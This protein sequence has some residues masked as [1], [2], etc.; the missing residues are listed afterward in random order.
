MRNSTIE[1]KEE[2]KTVFANEKNAK[3]AAGPAF[4]L[5]FA[6]IS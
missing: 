4:P 6:D 1:P 2:G 5:V 3:V